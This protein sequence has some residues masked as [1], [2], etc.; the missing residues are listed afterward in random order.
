MIKKKG[1][2]NIREIADYLGIHTSTVYRYAQQG[3]IPAF[4]IGSDW[5]F[6][7]KSIDNWIEDQ[8]NDNMTNMSQDKLSK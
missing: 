1:I 5:R 4:K 2:Y 6:T 3:K 8:V 7:K